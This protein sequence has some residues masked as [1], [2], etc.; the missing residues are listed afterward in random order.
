MGSTLV[1][2]PKV[3]L[4]LSYSIEKPN[5]ITGRAPHLSV[6]SW[7]PPL[8]LKVRR[9]ISASDI[10][11]LPAAFMAQQHM[12]TKL[13]CHNTVR[14]KFAQRNSCLETC[15]VAQYN[16]KTVS[17]PLTVWEMTFA[18]WYL[19][20]RH[21]VCLLLKKINTYFDH[22]VLACIENPVRTV[23]AKP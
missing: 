6:L 16:M 11:D 21:I 20:P 4:A 10:H 5:L 7:L 15:T 23:T 14:A 18:W 17:W 12:D 13:L 1:E 9:P 8:I 3:A 22:S 2:L 19:A